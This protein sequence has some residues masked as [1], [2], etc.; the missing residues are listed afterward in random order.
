MHTPNPKR[1]LPVVMVLLVLG[2]G[3]YL[4]SNGLLPGMTRAVNDANVVSGFIEGDEYTVA[5]ELTGRI[6]VV[7]VQ[8]GAAVQQGQ[9]LI[10]LDHAL[11][12]AQI[13]Q[14]QAAINTAQAQLALAQNPA[15][16]S[17]VTAAQGA[18][19]AAQENLDKVT[20][21]ATASDLAAAQAALK[22]AQ[23]NYD[24]LAAGPKASDLA[25]A[26]AAVNAAQQGYAKVKAGP[27]ADELGQIK[28]QMDNA[29]AAVNQAQAAYDK[30]GGASNPN[31]ALTPQSRALEQATNLYTAAVAAYNNALSHPTTAELA[32]AQ[33]AVDNAKAALARLTPDA[34]QLAGAQSQVDTAQAALSRLTPDAAQLA[35]A[36]S[37]VDQAQ[38]VL[39]RLTPLDAA[40]AVAQAQVKQAEAALT[41]LQVQLAKTKIV[42]PSN[43][44][45]TRRAVNPGELAA[46]NAVL[47]AISQLDPV[48]LTIYVP[49]TRLGDISLGSEMGVQVDSFPNRVFQG[50]IIHISDV[51]EFTPRNIQSKEERVNTVFAVKLQIPNATMELKAG[52]PADAV[53]P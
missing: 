21:G 22:A 38:A 45:V 28:A 37:Q 36:Q 51:A 3:Y 33:A 25:A 43:G 6:S 26:Q 50:K 40:I 44:I 23:E 11:L 42:A 13:A 7:N 4:W 12:D 41:L 46:P 24:K 31:I 39:N 2:G 15:R 53:L 5:S 48:E 34:A 49:E 14:A 16:A 32:A 1:I 17:D 18:L 9:V 19:K 52:M 20:N 47:I 30:I 35:G 8:E 29:L 10:E 27:T